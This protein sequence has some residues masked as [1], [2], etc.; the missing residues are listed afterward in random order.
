[1]PRHTQMLPPSSIPLLSDRTQAVPKSSLAPSHI[2]IKPHQSALP[3][4]RH[5]HNKSPRITPL[6]GTTRALFALDDNVK[7]DLQMYVFGHC[8][9]VK[10]DS[11]N[12][13]RF[14]YHLSRD[15]E[16]HGDE[17]VKVTG[18]MGIDL[19]EWVNG[20]EEGVPTVLITSPPPPPLMTSS[21][22]TTADV[23]GALVLRTAPKA[24]LRGCHS[25]PASASHMAIAE[26]CGK[27]E[28]KEKQELEE[29]DGRDTT[30]GTAR[31][32][33][34]SKMNGTS[35]IVKPTVL[36]DGHANAVEQGS[37]GPSDD[38]VGV[39][40]SSTEETSEGD[41][42]LADTANLKYSVQ[43]VEQDMVAV[44]TT[45]PR[46]VLPESSDVSDRIHT[47]VCHL[48]HIV[49]EHD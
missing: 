41:R 4:M 28:K 27:D 22:S 36:Y 14:V 6:R 29:G 34:G 5:A 30:A 9:A 19:R 37:S 47:Q 13:E 17:V 21:E 3:N 23:D 16:G 26:D 18:E 10:R 8:E 25:G 38:A 11:K 2:T 49:A 43:K 40:D 42:I 1:M 33:D 32:A 46:H 39:H 48:E 45:D 31:K 12:E 35:V 20:E 24:R 15:G 7:R 44:E